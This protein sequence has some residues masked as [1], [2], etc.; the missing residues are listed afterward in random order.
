M[1]AE[2]RVA[3]VEDQPLFRSM[4][5]CLLD[6][7]VGLR[8]VAQA[9]G[10]AEARRAI[11][12]GSVDVALLDVELQDGN[13]VGLGV[14]L[15]RA[16][17]AIGIMLLSAQDV[18]ELLLDLPAD[19]RRGW[20]YL[21]KTSSTS[22]E[23]LLA[24]VTATARGESVLD[25]DL[26][27]RSTPRAGSSLSGLSSRQYEVLGQVARGLSNQQVAERLD[28]STRSVENH[29]GVIYAALDVGA[30]ANARVGAVLRFIEDSS[31]VQ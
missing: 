2:I 8:V 9:S 21:S 23:T 3:V 4:L 1:D 25:P 28:I 22:P 30:G 11:T 15:R 13:G 18:M 17:P 27:H 5:V 6:A 10:A 20:S 14:S 16:D 7:Q 26:V 12:P 19:V 31:K 24:A 29:L